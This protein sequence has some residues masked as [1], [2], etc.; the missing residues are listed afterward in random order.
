MPIRKAS[1]M[2]ERPRAA[3]LLADAI[4]LTSFW[5]SH[6]GRP[7]RSGRMVIADMDGAR[8]G[9][10]ERV[11]DYQRR[12][13]SFRGCKLELFAAWKSGKTKWYGR[14]GNSRAPYQE[15]PSSTANCIRIDWRRSTAREIGTRTIIFDVYILPG[16]F[17]A[18]AS[19][20]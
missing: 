5:L 2:A 4:K 15:L 9:A 1:T 3:L 11:A 20:V 13:R 7:R 17:P 19:E 14:I 18:D 8:P 12:R 10:M 16:D 6:S